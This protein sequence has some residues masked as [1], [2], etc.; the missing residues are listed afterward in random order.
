MSENFQVNLGG[1]IDILA[2]HL[3]SG[4]QVYLRELL[5][6]ATD[7]IRARKAKGDVDFDPTIRIELVTP[8]SGPPTMVFED[9]GVGLTEDDVL[10]FLSTVGQSSKRQILD[11]DVDFIG[12][13]GIGLLSC[14]MVCEEIVVISRSLTPG[15]PTI[16]W[17]GRGDGTYEVEQLPSE[18]AI[19]TQVFIRSSVDAYEFFDPKFVGD[20]LARYGEFL[21]VAIELHHGGDVRRIDSTPPWE[22]DDCSS[23]DAIEDASKRLGGKILDAFPI[24][25]ESAG[26]N[27]VAYITRDSSAMATQR[28]HVVYLKRMLLSDQINNLLPEWA[29]FVRLI[30]N[31]ENLHPTASRETFVEDYEFEATREA[32][33]AAIRQYLLQLS[34]ESPEQ[35]RILLSVHHGAIKTLCVDDDECL[36]LFANWL[37]FETTLGRMTL[38]EIRKRTP[39]LPYTSTV[40]QFRAIEAVVQAQGRLLINAGYTHDTEVLNRLAEVD[41]ELDIHAFDSQRFVESFESIDANDAEQ[42]EQLTEHANALLM[43]RDCEADVVRFAPKDLPAL[44]VHNEAADFLKS[45]RQTREQS[46]ELWAGMLEQIADENEAAAYARL[47]LNWNHPLIRRIAV[48]ENPE[49][50]DRLIDVLY[51]QSLLQGRH[52]MDAQE[53]ELLSR[54]ILS[55]VD[56]ATQT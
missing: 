8:E 48:I 24:Q 2:N 37:P 47:F 43:P 40:D 12:R 49:L 28:P 25:V 16:R 18:A 3:Y 22:D 21:G 33:G 15:S 29:F 5:Q 35:F 51:A 44:F 45:I 38:G 34:H 30:A 14:F 55:L 13:F 4:P 41:D 11:R 53:R 32:L 6:N 27:G 7:A 20:S 42:A 9:N 56:F 46:D 17:T 36:K 39:R 52:R 23:D 19:G 50:R 54:G 31:V 26:L 10:R 1:L